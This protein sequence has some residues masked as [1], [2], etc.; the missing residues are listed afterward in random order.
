MGRSSTLGVPVAIDADR[1]G[2]G[3]A[4]TLVGPDG[5]EYVWER[6]K[7]HKGAFSVRMHHTYTVPRPFRDTCDVAHRHSDEGSHG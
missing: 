4:Q 2:T 7:K 3:R 1:T 6:H 5:E